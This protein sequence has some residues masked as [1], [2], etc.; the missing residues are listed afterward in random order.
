M[1]W[2]KKNLWQTLLVAAI[3]VLF[4]TLGSVFVYH[5]STDATKVD[6]AAS[7]DLVELK[8]SEQKIYIDEKDNAIIQ[9]MD[10]IQ[11]VQLTKAD[12]SYVD[13]LYQKTEENNRLLIEI[14]MKVK[15]LK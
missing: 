13:K 10:R 15:E 5:Y 3:T 4:S 2:I 1:D 14:L 11:A 12:Q 8:H 9:R 6:K 7:I